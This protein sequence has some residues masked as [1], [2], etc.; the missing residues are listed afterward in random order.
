MLDAKDNEVS[1]GDRVELTTDLETEN[2]MKV[3]RGT[4]GVVALVVDDEATVRGELA[5]KRRR[6]GRG[7]GYEL[8][9]GGAALKVVGRTWGF[10]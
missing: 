3:P 6:G 7:R 1:L 8:R 10:R 4:I 9:T 2:G 5:G